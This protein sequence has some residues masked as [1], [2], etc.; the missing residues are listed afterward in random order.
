MLTLLAAL[1]W[2][3]VV[4]IAYTYVGY[5]LIITLLARWR[6][7]P[8]VTKEITPTVTVLV[9]AYDEQDCIAAKIENTLQLDYPPHQLELLVATD[10]SRDGTPA[11]VAEYAAR[12]ANV[13]LLHDQER[14]GK[15]A[16]LARASARA[17]GE[18]L[19][20][21]DANCLFEPSTVRELVRPFADAAVGGVSGSKRIEQGDG[22]A[23]AQGEGLYWRYESYLKVCDSAVSSVMGAPGEVWATRRSAYVAPEQD[24]ILEDLTAALQL[25]QAGW[26]VVYCQNARAYETTSPSI[27]AQWRRRTRI[28]AGGWQAAFRL[29]GMLRHPSKLIVFQYVSHRLLRWMVTPALFL[30]LLLTNMG[31]LASPFYRVTLLGQAVFYGSAALGWYLAA[32][33]RRLGGLLIPFYLCLLNA[34]A[35]AG[36]IRFL[37]GRQPVTWDKVR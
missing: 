21:S 37:R 32:R 7:R 9:A 36:G 30:L 11:I 1:Y 34:A 29:R 28:I 35:L 20:F 5:A 12:H 23:T 17:R 10:G 19:I 3:S 33:R 4:G 6:P 14:R 26:R 13:H 27:T 18:I 2:L 25:V 22:Q 15:A 8:V 31:L 16:A 24:T